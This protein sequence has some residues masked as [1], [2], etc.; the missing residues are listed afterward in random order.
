MSKIAALTL[1]I[2]ASFAF[3]PGTAHAAD[4]HE[5]S[6]SVINVGFYPGVLTIICGA[7]GSTNFGFLN[8]NTSAGT[9]PTIDMDTLKIWTS[10]ALAARASGLFL[11]IWYT[12]SCGALG[13]ATYRSITSIEVKG[14]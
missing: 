7:T 14:N 10:Q 6:C 13:N 5:N 8:G 9:C 12:D 2:A 11:T 4:G 3:H 1:L